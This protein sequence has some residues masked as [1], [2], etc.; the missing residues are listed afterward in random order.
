[1][2]ALCRFGDAAGVADRLQGAEV[3]DIKFEHR[4]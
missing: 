3:A 4:Y 2:Q 1:M